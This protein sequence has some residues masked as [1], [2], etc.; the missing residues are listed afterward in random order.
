MSAAE[1][2]VETKASPQVVW[3]IW[4]DTSTWPQWNPD[5]QSVTLN[6][7]FR[8]GAIGQMTTKSGGQHDI[9]IETVEPGR[10][11][12]LVSTGLPMTKLVFHCE[13]T[14]SGSGS[15]ISQSVSLRGPLAPI[16]TG[17]MARR[18][19]DSFPALLRGLASQAE[20][21]GARA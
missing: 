18:I 7:A 20:A 16:F 21:S 5:M 10:S 13:V 11:F 2:S 19:G 15:R 4:S 6:G 1:H 12:D 9:V 3:S 8:T 17:M 14:P